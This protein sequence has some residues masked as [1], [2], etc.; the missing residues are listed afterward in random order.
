MKSRFICRFIL[1]LALLYPLMGNSAS[2]KRPNILIVSGWQNQNVGDIAHTPG[3]LSALHKNIPN[4]DMTVWIW[5]N[6][7]TTAS[8]GRFI[9]KYFPKVKVVSGD[10]SDNLTV[11]SDEVIKSM[12]SADL[13]IHGSGPMILGDKHLA[14]FKKLTGKPYGVFGATIQ[15]TTPQLTKLLNGA[16][17][18]YTRE[19]A[20]CD[21]L[22]RFG[23]NKPDIVR[24]VPDAV[25]ALRMRNE[26]LVK[27]WL[28]AHNIEDKG[29][30]CVI[31]RLRRT[32]YPQFSSEELARINHLNDSCKE[33]DH[34]KLREMITQW[35]RKT[36]KKV[37]VC[38][39]MTYQVH[40]FNELL[41][42]KLPADVKPYVY[43]HDYW[44]PDE[45]TSF[46]T[47]AFALVSLECHS[48]I[49]ALAKG[50]P[51]FYV[52]QPEDTVKG[53]MYY[54]LGFGNWVFDV[55]KTNGQQL[56]DC[57]LDIYNNPE[58]AYKLIKNNIKTASKL[59]DVG[60]NDIKELMHW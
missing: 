47:H 28:K 34:A 9:K 17:F 32:P 55:D 18:I 24:F 52:R 56:S 40:L 33:K 25:F 38:A 27:K 20:S 57:L 11:K 54:D 23:I 12:L 60:S 14:A 51:A 30:I 16:K 5:K 13:M 22:K 39:E 10:V 58:P 1:T 48:V 7:S 46:L 45:A 3:I 50:T 59:I 21:S 2:K 42:D 6:D 41:I 26:K 29:Y 35:V 44:W 36:H 43:K 15:W 37:V 4:A 49:M 8:V 53:Q 31:P 19:T